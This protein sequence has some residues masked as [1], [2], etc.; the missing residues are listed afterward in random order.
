MEGRA[1]RASRMVG[2]T[3]KVGRGVPA[4]PLRLTQ[5]VRPT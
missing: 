2:L 3:Y 4:E 5:R 1:L